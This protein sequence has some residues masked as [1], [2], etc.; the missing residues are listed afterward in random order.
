MVTKLRVILLFLFVAALKN[1]SGQAPIIT[2]ATSPVTITPGNAVSVH[3]TNTGGTVPANQYFQVSTFAGSNAGVAGTAGYVNGTGTGALF[4]DPRDMAFDAS[5]NLYVADAGNNAIRKITP[6]GVVTTFAGSATGTAGYTDGNGSSALFNSPVGLCFDDAGNLFVSDAGNGA[7]RTITPAGVVSTFYKSDPMYF[8]PAGLCFN[9]IADLLVAVPKSSQIIWI[10]QESIV[11]GL[12]SSGPNGAFTDIKQDTA[13]N[14]YIT[15]PGRNEISKFG[16]LHGDG[17]GGGVIAGN[18]NA[19][20]FDLTGVG[21]NATFTQPTGIQVMPDGTAYVADLLNNDIRKISPQDTVSVLAGYVPLNGS[22]YPTQQP[23]Y[24]DGAI[25]NAQFNQPAYI[26]ADHN[27]NLYVS[28]WGAGGNR[29]RKISQTG[30][31][32]SGPPLPGGLKFDA[33]TGTISGTPMKKV[34]ISQTDT[35]T[36]VNASGIST[37]TITF[38]P[39][40]PTPAPNISYALAQLTIGT[41]VTLTPTNT[42]GAVPAA[43]YG[44]VS[45]FVGSPGEV[46]GN[47]PGT[48]TTARFNFPQTMEMDAAGNL[49]IADSQNN[50][51][52]KVTP[53]GYVNT[54]AGSGQ[55]AAGFQDGTGSHSLFDYPDGTAMDASGNIYVAD[56]KNNA[57]RKVT[58][59]GIVTTFYTSATTFG[60][61]GMCFD[62]SGNLVVSAQ[63]ANQIWQITPAGVASVLAGTTTA[64]YVNAAAAV[65][66]FNTP[67]D[68]K[69][70]PTGNMYVADNKNN[71][72]RKITPAG[73]VSTVAGSAVSGN[74]P[75]YANGNGTAAIFNYPAGIL[76]APGGVIYVTDMNN[77]DIRRIMPDGTV[78]LVAGSATQAKGD[79]DGIGTAAGFYVPAY[80]YLNDAGTGYISEFGGER[81]RKIVLTGYSLTGTLPPGLTFDPATGTI[82]GTPTAV[83]PAAACTITAYNTSGISSVVVNLTVAPGTNTSLTGLTASTGVLSPAFATATTSYTI[84]EPNTVTSIQ[85]TPTTS[86]TTATVTINGSIVASGALSPPI[87]LS[88]GS[89]PIL[90]TVVDNGGTTASNYTVTVS[91]APSTNAN[92]SKLG[93]GIGG[94][95]PSFNSTTTSYAISAGNATASITLTPVSSDANATIKVNGA[96]VTSGT[97]TTPIALAEGAQTVINAVVTAQDGTTTKTYTLTVMRAPSTVATLSKLGPSIGGLTPAFSPATT[98]YTISTGNATASMTLTPVSSDANATIKVNGATVTS[99]TVTTPIALTEGAQTVI[100]TVVTAQDGATTKTYTITVTRAPSANAAL[101]KLGPSIGGLTPA[102]SATTTSYTLSTGNATTS[103][104]L[105]PVSSDANATIKVNGTTV[106]SGTVFGPIALAPGPNTITTVVTA[107]DGTTT[108]TYTLTVTRAANGVNSYNAGIS[109][110]IPIAIGKTET[111]ALAEDGIQVHQGVS[112]NGDGVN[113]FLMIDNISQY[114]DNKLSIMNRNGQ[115]IYEAQGYDNSSKVFDGHSNKNGQMQLPGTY[116]YSLDY[117]VSGVVKHKTGFIVLKY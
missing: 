1:A 96:T 18:Y 68:V 82:S 34:A 9:S 88:V 101:S 67:T 102:F 103:M 56:Y 38:T 92:L 23:G 95:T 28:E 19:T 81:I 16:Y 54:L 84:S 72:I 6:A 73:M 71:A 79:A 112:P 75:G 74:T 27:G 48:D 93:P 78:G 66:Q 107:Q 85:L 30:F 43:P 25:A 14:L 53:G 69:V 40:S 70:D 51:I 55:E 111:P 60:P 33:A 3:A 52:R 59:A 104:K 42:G 4:N 58:P 36:A 45:V 47:Q 29:I 97:V 64:G 113:D 89:N 114:P 61:G 109:V 100:T 5:N 20:A 26:R 21:Q 12:Y 50:G 2:Y 46:S 15:D 8:N 57:I 17:Y 105:T 65:A 41:A 44:T 49:Y 115:M 110:T 13:G 77:N 106:T 22:G 90:I 31:F 32:L 11:I 87:P 86:D 10:T 94:L 83:T 24:A 39:G 37:T 80:M 7:I 62:N 98:S 99:G 35:V 108:K 76:L 91:R 63:D 117:T 116:F